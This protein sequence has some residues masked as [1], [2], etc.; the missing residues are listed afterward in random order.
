M[1]RLPNLRFARPPLICL[2]RSP[3]INIEDIGSVHLR[4]RYP[5]REQEPVQLIRGDIKIDGPTIFITFSRA[6]E[7]WPF[8]IENHSDYTVAISQ[9]VILTEFFKL[10]AHLRAGFQLGGRGRP[11]EN[12]CPVHG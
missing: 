5:G 11:Q 6:T 4:L 3:P 2:L 7:T 12:E 1:V 10:P 9:K 8:V